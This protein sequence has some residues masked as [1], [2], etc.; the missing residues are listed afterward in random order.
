MTPPPRI[1]DFAALLSPLN[2]AVAHA[3]NAAPERLRR[4]RPGPAWPLHS[5]AATRQLE[6]AHMAGLPPHTLMQ[7]AGLSVARLALAVAPHARALWVACGPG[8]NGGDG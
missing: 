4:V 1:V 2:D 8:N 7:R 3:V 6:T 5:V